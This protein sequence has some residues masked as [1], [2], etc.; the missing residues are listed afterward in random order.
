MSLRNGNQKMSKSDPSEYSRINLND[1]ADEIAQKIRKA[2]TDPEPLPSEV[3]GL[4]DRPEAEN[5]VG[6]Y[7]GLSDSTPED[8]LRDVGGDQFSAFKQQLTELAVSELGPI[9]EEMRRL[10]S[11][12]AEIDAVLRDGGERARALSRPVLEEVFEAAGFLRG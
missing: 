9:G 6:I 1:S 5:L 4:V 10:M 11:D 7:A 3:A 8:V 2:K 12:P